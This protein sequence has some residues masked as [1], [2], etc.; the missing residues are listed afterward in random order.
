MTPK[1]TVTDCDRSDTESPVDE[2]TK[3]KATTVVNVLRDHGL[4]FPSPTTRTRLV[5]EHSFTSWYDSSSSDNDDTDSDEEESDSD[6]DDDDD[7]ND[8]AKNDWGDE[9]PSF[10]QHGNFP[11]FSLEC[12]TEILYGLGGDVSSIR[13]TTT[14][15]G[16]LH[17][18]TPPKTCE[19]GS[20]QW[21]QNEA[22]FL[23]NLHRRSIRFVEKP[24][25]LEFESLP[26]SMHAE[27]YYSCHQL[28]KFMD[29]ANAEKAS[30]ATDSE[31]AGTTV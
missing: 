8:D 7:E 2:P 11:S 15:F 28:Q 16:R 5:Y 27:L 24:Q 14:T 3:A 29:E 26:L 1:D 31:T 9:S 6:S 25:V 19:V 13:S 10:P 23:S 30:A 22:V 4:L 12:E 21:Q 17:P 18:Q 20:K